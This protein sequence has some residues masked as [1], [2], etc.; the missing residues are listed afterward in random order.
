MM[1]VRSIPCMLRKCIMCGISDNFIQFVAVKK[2]FLAD[3]FVYDKTEI[4]FT[5]NL[6]TGF[7]KS[8]A[9]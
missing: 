6:K 5:L 4:R 1:Q 3:L 7:D 8:I 2:Q 9:V